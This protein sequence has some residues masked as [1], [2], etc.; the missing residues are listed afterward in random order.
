MATAAYF[1]LCSDTN[2]FMN[3][4]TDKRSF[5]AA[6]EMMDYDVEASKVAKI[7]F[8]SRSK[9]SFELE[10]IVLDRLYVDTENRFDLSYLTADNYEKYNATKDDSDASIDLLRTLERIDVACVIR[11]EKPGEKIRGSLRSKTQTDVSKLAKLH[12]G[13]GHKAAAGF[14]MDETDMDA[15]VKIIKKQLEDLMQGKI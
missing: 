9:E 5:K 2:S 15:A 6:C 1:G 10:K 8:Q 12:I 13:G 7:L 14:T 11:Q 3:T 4:N